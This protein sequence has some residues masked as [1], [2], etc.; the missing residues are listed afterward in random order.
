MK[1]DIKPR[2][3]KGQKHGYWV[4]Y[5]ND[6]SIDFRGNWI[7]DIQVGYWEIYSQYNKKSLYGKLKTKLYY[8]I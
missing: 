7:N 2:N 8:I 5:W 4:S 1:K 6:Y 3:D